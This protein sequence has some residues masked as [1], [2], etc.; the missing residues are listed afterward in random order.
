MTRKNTVTGE[1]EEHPADQRERRRPTP[2]GQFRFNWDTPIIFSPHEPG[3]LIVAAQPRVPVDRSRR[4]VDGHQRRSDDERRPQRDRH[5]GPAGQSRSA[6]RAN[7]GITAWPTIVSLAES[8]K[9]PGLYFTGTDDGT[10]SVS[11]DGGKKWENIT[12]NLPGFPA[13]AWVSEVV[14]SKFDAGTVYVTVDAHRLNDYDTLHLGEQ[15]LRRDVPVDQR[16]T[17]KARSSRRSPK[18]SRTRT[19]STSAPKPASFL[20]L[21]R[22]KSWRRL[23]ANL[24]TVRVDE[25]TLHPRDNAMIVA[26]HGRA[27]WI[28]DHLEPIQE[29]AAAQAADAKL[30]TPGPALQWKTK[31]DR[32]DEFWGH[33]FFIGENPP[34]EAVIQFHLK[35]AVDRRQV[36][37]H[38]YGRKG[39]PRADRSR[40]AERQPGIQTIVLGHAR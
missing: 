22:G 3:T 18:T 21:D 10:V 13:G 28:L 31:D 15:R 16:A 26:T 5:D 9:Q 38:R 4:F 1:V 23:K 32:N 2:Q 34:A 19:C 24:P 14:P 30:F 7:D 36:A 17:S 11:R 29:F 25:I 12:K 39:G 40:R 6:S 37:D 20:T 33:Q 8:P 27:L 35:N